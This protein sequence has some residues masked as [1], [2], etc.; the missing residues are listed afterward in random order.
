LT[1][2]APTPAIAAAEHQQATARIGVSAPT[3]LREAEA[4]SELSTD[5]RVPFPRPS[6]TAG[7]L[8][9]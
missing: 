4:S 6:S 1:R 9:N 7:A 5:R 8:A 2:K 3:F